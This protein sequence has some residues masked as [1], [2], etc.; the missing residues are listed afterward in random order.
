MANRF[1]TF[2]LSRNAFKKNS[3]RIFSVLYL[4]IRKNY[5]ES[6][7]SNPL[8]VKKISLISIFKLPMLFKLLLSND[9]DIYFKLERSNLANI[10]E[11][12]TIS[13]IESEKKLTIRD[14]VYFLRAS[15]SLILMPLT[16]FFY[17]HLS[18]KHKKLLS[19]KDFKS[20][21]L[22]MGDVFFV[23]IVRFCLKINK[24]PIKLFYAA[25]IM[26]D[27]TI[28]FSGRSIIEVSHGVIH[29]GHPAYYLLENR[30][31][32]I[33]VES[34]QQEKKVIN[35]GCINITI[36]NGQ[37]F[38]KYFC[39]IISGPK[40]FICQFGESYEDEASLFL[41]ENNDYLVRFHP[42]NSDSFKKRFI[43]R[44]YN[45]CEVSLVAS[46]SSSMI[47][48]AHL[49]KIPYKFVY[50]DNHDYEI[51]FKYSREGLL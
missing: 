2:V 20:M 41:N 1:E 22:A 34:N 9:R 31:L 47:L 10:N 30:S 50:S 51:E 37:F 16:S 24:N 26:P 8:K 36:V 14:S 6:E 49:S 4:Y 32:P 35:N 21:T 18:M 29:F 19:L 46:I 25:A 42:R 48:D 23:F 38:S 7:I 27:A 15:L 43:S 5:L 13:F 11:M 3:N 45:K 39:Y 28:F 12:T 33:I 17:L 44:Q 40:L